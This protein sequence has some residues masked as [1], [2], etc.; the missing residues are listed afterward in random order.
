MCRMCTGYAAYTCTVVS[1]A[2][3]H[4]AACIVSGI[5][6]DNTLLYDLHT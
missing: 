3:V 4:F 1:Q 6:E 5:T 2:Y